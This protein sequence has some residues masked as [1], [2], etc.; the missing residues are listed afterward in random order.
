MNSNLILLVIVAIGAWC[1]AKP[2]LLTGLRKIRSHGCGE[3][4]LV[5]IYNEIGI[6]TV[7]EILAVLDERPDIRDEVIELL[8]KYDD[9]IRVGDG[10]RWK[11][12]LR[13]T[14]LSFNYF[15]NKL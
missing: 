14:L 15:K 8:R 9:C 4:P 1:E 6:M 10:M 11:K 3:H 2:Q 7:D 13:E 5:A 12:D